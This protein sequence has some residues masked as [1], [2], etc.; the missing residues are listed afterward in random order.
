MNVVIVVVCLLSTVKLRQTT[1]NISEHT[2]TS[3]EFDDSLEDKDRISQLPVAEV[4]TSDPA[5]SRTPCEPRLL[6]DLSDDL[7]LIVFN[8]LSISDRSKIERGDP[9]ELM[10]CVMWIKCCCFLFHTTLL[11][12][13]LFG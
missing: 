11:K 7:W 12:K 9:D 13:R 6:S 5:V 4:P 10:D 8:Y 1:S 3:E 2:E